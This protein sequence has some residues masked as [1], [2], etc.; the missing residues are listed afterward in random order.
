MTNGLEAVFSRETQRYFAFSALLLLIL[1][2]V[3]PVLVKVLINIYDG[4]LFGISF[5]TVNIIIFLIVSPFV[6]ESPLTS[7]QVFAFLA[8]FAMLW[9][10]LALF[11]P[12]IFDRDIESIAV[13]KDRRKKFYS[14]KVWWVWYVVYAELMLL[15]IL[16]LLPKL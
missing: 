14:P 9:G 3:F 12:L 1:I 11:G 8:M 4:I 2:P 13:A 16:F 6:D 7:F 10:L 5:L 15:V